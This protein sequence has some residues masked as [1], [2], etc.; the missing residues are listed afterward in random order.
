MTGD[1]SHSLLQGQQSVLD[2]ITARRWLCEPMGSRMVCKTTRGILPHRELTTHPSVGLSL[3]KKVPGAAARYF[4]HLLRLGPLWSTW[5][6][7]SRDCHRPHNLQYADACRRD[8]WAHPM[9]G[10][11]F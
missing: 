5:G 2:A 7:A 6:D 10:A 1:V 11:V 8:S 4:P 3:F 9:D